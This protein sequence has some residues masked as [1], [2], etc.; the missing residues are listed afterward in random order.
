[1]VVFG[2]YN[3]LFAERWH[4][5]RAREAEIGLLIAMEHPTKPMQKEVAEAG[6]YRSPGL[7]EK[8]PRIRISGLLKWLEEERI[9]CPRSAGGCDVQEGSQGLRLGLIYSTA[10]RLGFGFI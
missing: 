9:D 1:M 8:Y 3:V 7:A 2:L 5:H 6:F 10:P 4:P